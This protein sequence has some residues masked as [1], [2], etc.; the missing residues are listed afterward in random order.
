MF[1]LMG[2]GVLMAMTSHAI[3]F[4]RGWGMWVGLTAIATGFVMLT[5]YR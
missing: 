2:V 3:F 1:S 4:L 5:N